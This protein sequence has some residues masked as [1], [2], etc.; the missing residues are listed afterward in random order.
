MPAYRRARQRTAELLPPD[1]SETLTSLV[2]Y[3]FECSLMA[4]AVGQPRA[5]SRP[6][7]Y[8]W[9]QEVA[10]NSQ[11]LWIGCHNEVPRSVAGRGRSCRSDR[12][13]SLTIPSV[14]GT[15]PVTKRLT[16]LP[17]DASYYDGPA[18]WD[19]GQ[20]QPAIVRLASECE[21]A[22]NKDPVFGV[23]GIQSGPRG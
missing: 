20:P 13:P 5:I 23:I 14:V 21:S 16:G 11:D 17:W 8:E 15:Q 10:R 1:T 6:L 7:Q 12:E 22:W 3:T 19:I 2:G 18:P 4:E 9:R